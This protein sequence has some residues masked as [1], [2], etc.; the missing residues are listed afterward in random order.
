M[1]TQCPYC[2]APDPQIINTDEE[3]QEFF[4]SACDRAWLEAIERSYEPDNPCE[5]GHNFVTYYLPDGTAYSE[6]TEC[7]IIED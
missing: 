1:A 2:G 7:G 6:C 4:C 5:D 3:D